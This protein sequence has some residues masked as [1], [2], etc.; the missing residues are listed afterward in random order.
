MLSK[1][2]IIPFL[3]IYVFGVSLVSAQE[4]PTAYERSFQETQAAY[5][6]ALNANTPS[7]DSENRTADSSSDS[8][9]FNSREVVDTDN[10]ETQQNIFSGFNVPFAEWFGFGSDDDEEASSRDSGQVYSD[11]EIERLESQAASNGESYYDQSYAGSSSDDISDS[12][13]SGMS[14]EEPQ[15]FNRSSASSDSS[16]IWWVI[17]LMLIIIGILLYF[18]FVRRRK[19]RYTQKNTYQH[20]DPSVHNYYNDLR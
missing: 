2:Y 13:Y 9:T 19:K 11:E 1:K 17:V 14:D 20:T 3:L 5:R 8:I 4:E 10:T 12:E 7:Y 6:E 16:M 15:T 18:I